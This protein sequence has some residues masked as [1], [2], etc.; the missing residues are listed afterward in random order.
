MLPNWLYGKS[1]SKLQEILGGGGGGTNY[2]AGNGIDISNGVISFDPETTPAIDPSKIDGLDDNL[3]ALAPKSAISNLNLLDN[4]WFTVNQRGQ[5]SYTA[6]NYTLDRWLIYSNDTTKKITVSNGVTFDSG[7]SGRFYQTLEDDMIATLMGKTVTISVLLS[8]GTIISSN[9]ELPSTTP[10][11]AES[12][13]NKQ[14]S[15]QCYVRM[16]FTGT[17][18]Q[19]DIHTWGIAMPASLSI[20][21]V[22]LELGSV[23]TLAMDAAPNYATELAKCQRYFYKTLQFNNNGAIMSPNQCVAVATTR[24]QGIKFPTQMRDN[25]NI[26][27]NKVVELDS[28]TPIT[29]V[30]AQQNTKEGITYFSIAG[31]TVGSLYVVDFEASAEF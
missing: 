30:T 20:R 23:S 15:E 6:S 8:N 18:W 12:F 29:G 2:T 5:S 25:P 28:S 9:I 3:A 4:P 17:K 14:I 22:K 24:L 31:A 21:A 1:K 19:F 16:Y 13:G 26:T 10:S 7:F 27:I 11:E